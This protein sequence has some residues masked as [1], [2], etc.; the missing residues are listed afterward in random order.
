M[1]SHKIESITKLKSYRDSLDFHIE[2]IEIN[3]FL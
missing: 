1:E 3:D 2:F